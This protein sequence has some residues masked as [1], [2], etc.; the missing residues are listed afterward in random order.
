MHDPMAVAHEILRPWPTLRRPRKV[1]QGK[2]WKLRG[3]F[4]RAFGYEFYRPAMV[5][6]WHVEPKGRDSG[7]VCKHYIRSQNDDGTWT[8]TTITRWKWHVHHWHIQ[9]PM[10]Q[11]VRAR[12]FDRCEECGRKG[13]PNVSHQWDG[14]GVGWRKWQ[15]RRGLYHS[16]CSSLIQFRRSTETD[17]EIIRHLFAAYRLAVDLSDTEAL[18]K[19]TDPRTRGLEFLAAQRLTRAVGFNR[20]DN[21]DLVRS[22]PS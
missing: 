8:A 16:Q 1:T 4:P 11:E 10:L 19:L 22:D 15:S 18:S 6:I 21:Y 20:N 9:L 3:H 2:R 17:A 14:P 5:T 13:R 12:L 7:E